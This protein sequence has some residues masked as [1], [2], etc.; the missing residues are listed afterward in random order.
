MTFPSNVSFFF[1]LNCS[2]IAPSGKALCS[3]SNSSLPL[4]FRLTHAG[5][6]LLSSVKRVS[7][8]CSRPL[9]PPPHRFTF[10]AFSLLVRH[11]ASR[12][13]FS[14]DLLFLTSDFLP[15][16]QITVILE[17][18]YKPLP[19]HFLLEMEFPA[20]LHRRWSYRASSE[21]RVDSYRPLGFTN[22][23]SHL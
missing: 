18:L 1:F 5:F 3:I 9:P 13:L 6:F 16:W 2:P 7:F 17:G 12:C 14:G 15:D 19:S 21:R 23:E 11:H 4:S 22:W 20:H 10:A 8:F